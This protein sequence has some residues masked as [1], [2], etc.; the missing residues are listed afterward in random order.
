MLIRSLT[1]KH[2]I[3]KYYSYDVAEKPEIMYL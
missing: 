2:K 1:E 3:L